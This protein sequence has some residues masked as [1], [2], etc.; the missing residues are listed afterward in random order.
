MKKIVSYIFILIIIAIFGLI[1]LN[2]IVLPL[3]VN[4]NKS[5]YL[6]DC[7]NIDYRIGKQKLDSL[8]FI[9]NIIFKEFNDNQIP[10]TIIETS[11]KPFTK[12]KSGRI[13]KLIVAG[14]KKDII[15]ES[16]IDKSI[17]NTYLELNRMTIAI[18]TL[19]YEY[20]NDI[21]KDYIISQYPK[22]GKLIKSGDE[23]V[24]IVSQGNAPNYYMTP[25]L[26]NMSLLRAKETI[27]KAGLLI[28]NIEYEFNTKYLN[29]TVLEQSKT[30]GMKL[31]FPAKIDLIVSK[32]K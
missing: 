20:N 13:I 6:P 25:N 31:S 4:T 5:I 7:R 29:N 15:L 19:I 22:A 11:P 2:S 30:S 8:G 9:S 23:I 12:L 21:P 26:I 28:G 27:S 32:D 16:F 10:F 14:D 3:I 18:D 24:F 1:T 17:R